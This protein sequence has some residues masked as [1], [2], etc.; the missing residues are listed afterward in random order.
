MKKLQFS[1]E[2][3]LAFSIVLVVLVA[4]LAQ[5]TCF[6]IFTDE[7][8]YIMW[9]ER[10]RNG[11]ENLFVSLNDG[12][13]PLFIWMISVWSKVFGNNPLFSGRFSSV[14]L[15]LLFF[16]FILYFFRKYYSFK[17]G[18]LV[19]FVLAF[20]P[21]IYFH[22]RLS[23]MDAPLAVFITTALLFWITPKVKYHAV[24]TGF[25]LGLAYLIKTPA[26]FL[27]PFPLLSAVIFNR[28]LKTYIKAAI[29]VF[30]SI[31]IL[32][33]LR[34]SV[35]FP[36]L[37]S[38]SQDFTF[39]LSEIINGETNHIAANVQNFLDAVVRYDSYPLL[40]AVIISIFFAFKTKHKTAQ[41]FY[42]AATVFIVPFILFGKVISP[43]YYLPAIFL[44]YTGMALVI[45][46]IK[47]RRHLTAVIVMLLIVPVFQ[48]TRLLTDYSRFS[49]PKKDEYQYLKEWSSGVGI[50]E[51]INYL[52]SEAKNKKIV[53][54][55]EGFHGTTPDSLYI[56]HSILPQNIKNNIEIVPVQYIG[57]ELFIKA[58][59]KYADSSVYYIGHSN[60]ITS[61]SLAD[62]HLKLV[63]SYPKKDN[64]AALQLYRKE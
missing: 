49:F 2:Y 19:L 22:G 5:L 31:L 20:S 54:L 21:F 9:A 33:T 1:R 24:Y 41:N 59:E 38:R 45:S 51:V 50:K 25:F 4:Y 48:I 57:N 35:F 10:I 34:V 58:L 39:S 7:A 62:Y 64:Y 26:L 40:L 47:D 18:M 42:L 14:F 6:P 12:K 23:L 56:Y 53:V 8:I 60:R 63:Q 36:K 37:F 16:S 43:R 15:L 52:S 61:N 44:L 32:L 17:Q 30:I 3:I 55:T 27:I 29:S 28:N 46:K 11:T 13:P